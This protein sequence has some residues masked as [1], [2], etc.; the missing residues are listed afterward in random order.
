MLAKVSDNLSQHPFSTTRFPGGIF[1]RYG[2]FY[3]IVE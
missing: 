2:N 1:L 3:K